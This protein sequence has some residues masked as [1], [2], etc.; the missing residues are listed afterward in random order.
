MKE[1]MSIFLL[2]LS[3]NITAS[4]NSLCSLYLPFNL[5]T[6]ILSMGILGH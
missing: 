1:Y 6:L 2:L 5:Y 3:P 4:V